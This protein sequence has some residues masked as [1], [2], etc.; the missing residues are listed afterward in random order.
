MLMLIFWEEKRYHT[1]KKETLLDTS[2]ELGLEENREK[3]IYV[4]V[5]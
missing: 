4:D 1:E 3:P 2:K 5:L